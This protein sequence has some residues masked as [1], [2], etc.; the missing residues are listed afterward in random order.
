MLEPLLRQ[1]AVAG[2]RFAT[3]A[4]EMMG[5]LKRQAIELDFDGAAPAGGPAT[6][7]PV[8]FTSVSREGLSVVGEGQLRVVAWSEI[9]AVHAGVAPVA[10]RKVLLVDIVVQRAPPLALRLS[11]DDAAVAALFPGTPAGQAWRTFFTKLVNTAKAPALPPGVER[12]FAAFESPEAVTASWAG[13]AVIT[14]SEAP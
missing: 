7:A 4:E 14:G 10:G 5:S 6:A 11:S 1:A 9:L 12:S 3:E 2:G 8:Q 13:S